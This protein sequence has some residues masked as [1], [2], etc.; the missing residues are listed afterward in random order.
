YD[1]KIPVKYFEPTMGEPTNFFIME[2]ELK[3]A[4]REDQFILYYQPLIS[5][6]TEKLVGFEAL[7][8]WIHPSKGIIPPVKFIHL[9]EK[10]NLIHDIGKLVFKKACRQLSEW[11]RLGFTDIKMSV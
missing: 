1:N 11:N 7:I 5:I 6:E 9:A 10:S 3:R 8:R 2:L 4:I